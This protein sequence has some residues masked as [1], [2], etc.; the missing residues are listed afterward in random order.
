M[1]NN[2]FRMQVFVFDTIYFELNLI[3]LCNWVHVVFNMNHGYSMLW[4]L[5]GLETKL[6]FASV[7]ALMLTQTDPVPRRSRI[8]HNK[9]Q[10]MCCVLI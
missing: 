10:T 4:N 9:K 1:V 5:L 8:Y 7:E 3:V 2:V 6:G